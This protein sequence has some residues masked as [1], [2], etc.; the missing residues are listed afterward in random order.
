H[1]FTE[2]GRDENNKPHYDVKLKISSDCLR[3][4][5]FSMD[6]PFQNNTI[7]HSKRLLNRSIAS[8]AG[9]L[10]GYMFEA[11]GFTGL[12]RKSP[13]IIVD[14][15]Q[16]CNSLSTIDLH[17]T[18]GAKKKNY[19]DDTAGT[20]F[21]YKETIG[22]VEYGFY[23]AINLTELQ[24]IS[25]SEVF[26]RMAVNPDEFEDLYR[27]HLEKSIGEKVA[28]PGYYLMKNAVNPLPEEGV[29]LT[30]AQTIFLV[31]EFFKRLLSLNITRSASAY[32]SLSGLQVKYVRN[33]ITDK[34]D[35]EDGWIIIKEID[36]IKID[37]ITTAYESISDLAA[38]EML[39]DIEDGMRQARQVRKALAAQKENGKKGEKNARKSVGN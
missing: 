19:N 24:F 31:K 10:R 8:V 32:A 14:A 13:V 11:V 5:I 9:L 33:P 28:D 22:S 20:S 12:K 30:Q 36:D 4:A 3:N 17:S 25:L 27:P 15:E 38:K 21:F 18:S 6:F 26:D 37:H 29:L 35:S 7:M 1:T 23:G 16:T 34:M 39:N 2:I